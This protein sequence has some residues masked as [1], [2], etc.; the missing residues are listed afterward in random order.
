MI[1]TTQKKTNLV[2]RGLRLLTGL[3][4]RSANSLGPYPDF[5]FNGLAT[6][7]APL[8]R[9]R[10]G[11]L[12]ELAVWPGTCAVVTARDGTSRVYPAGSHSL[13]DLPLGSATV[14]FV[15]TARQRRVLAPVEGLSQDKWRVRL[16]AE[17]EFEVC[18][19]WRVAQAVQPLATLDA[20]VTSCTLAQI[21]AM[22]HDALTGN[23]DGVGATPC[24][25]PVGLEAITT[26]IL[27][28]VRQRESLDGLWVVDLIIVER[29]GDERRVQIMQEA[30]VERARLSEEQRTQ[31]QFNQ[32]RLHLLETRRQLLER[33]QVLALLETQG[34]LDRAQIEEGRRLV[35][36]R[37]DAEVA[38]IRQAEEEWQAD[39]QQ[40]LEEQAATRER[41]N[42]AMRQRHAETLAV[43]EGTTLVTA[44]ATHAGALELPSV[45]AR[46]YPGLGPNDEPN[47]LASQ[48]RE[49]ESVRAELVDKGLRVLRGIQQGEAAPGLPLDRLRTLPE[50]NV[51]SSE[52]EEEDEHEAQG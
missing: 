29:V 46:R 43:I 15:H 27:Q 39:L 6:V 19:P 50:G 40:Q 20:V 24:G 38:R 16:S 30:S 49:I 42:L 45:S 36:A 48:V 21:E 3:D 34:Q 32:A 37:V 41:S 35:A 23:D 17:V 11:L 8:D 5:D 44:E 1:M 13:L 47:A 25:R 33:E 10:W 18:E 14:Q 31:E 12:G 28:R 9:G 26:G 22:T 4:R 51:S 2:E 52:E 7:P